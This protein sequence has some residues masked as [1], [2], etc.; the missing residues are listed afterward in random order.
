MITFSHSGFFIDDVPFTPMIS[1]GDDVAVCNG[2]RIVLPARL[3]DELDWAPARAAAQQAVG[4]GKRLFWEFDFGLGE[5]PLL[6]DDQAPFFA[7]SIALEQF[8]I[9]LWPEFQQ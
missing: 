4:E 6:L 1:E 2:V 7:F 3:A 8:K 9:T 5:Q